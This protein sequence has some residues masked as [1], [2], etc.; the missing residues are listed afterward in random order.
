MK[1][2]TNP[3]QWKEDETIRAGFLT[4]GAAANLH[5]LA[6]IV[7]ATS[8]SETPRPPP[9]AFAVGDLDPFGESDERLEVWSSQRLRLTRTQ[10]YDCNRGVAGCQGGHNSTNGASESCRPPGWE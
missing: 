1:G 10:R 8:R 7:A 9:G 3:S 6:T 4:G 5:Q 2:K